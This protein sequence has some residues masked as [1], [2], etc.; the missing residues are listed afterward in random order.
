[1]PLQS[2]L[3]EQWTQFL[4]EDSLVPADQVSTDN[5][6]GSLANQTNLAIKGIVGIQAMA[7]VARLTDDMTKYTNYS[8]RITS[9]VPYPSARLISLPGACGLLRPAM[10]ELRA[11]FVWLSSDPLGT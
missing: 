9:Y 10:A 5:F 2:G 6:A 3:L 11:G 1:M 4:V 7:E 8:V